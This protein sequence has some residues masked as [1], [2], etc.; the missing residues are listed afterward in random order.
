MVVVGKKKNASMY[1]VATS[2]F[3]FES[4]YKYLN[5][6]S[7]LMPV[8]VHSSCVVKIMSLLQCHMGSTFL[9]YDLSSS[10]T[11]VRNT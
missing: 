6:V 1:Q 9:A 8:S 4:K 10:T 7:G 11:V 2:A 3:V 5:V